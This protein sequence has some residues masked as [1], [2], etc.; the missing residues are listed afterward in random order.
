MVIVHVAILLVNNQNQLTGSI[1][2]V[3]CIL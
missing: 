3:Y 2:K 1:A